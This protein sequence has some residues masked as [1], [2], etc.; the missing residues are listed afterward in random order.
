MNRWIRKIVTFTSLAGALALVPA[1]S[2]LAGEAHD[3]EQPRHGHHPHGGLVSEALKLDSL[4]GAQRD[5]LGQIEQERRAA[6]V[7][8]RQ[9]DAALLTQLAHQ[10]EQA[11]IDRTALKGQLD[12]E[13]SAAATAQGVDARTLGQLHALLTTTQRNRLV[14]QVEARLPHGKQ[15]PPALEAFRGETFDPSALVHPRTPGEHAVRHAE[16]KVPGMTPAQ[17]AAFA[18]HLR[19]RAAREAR[20]S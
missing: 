4:S 16:A 20:A 10:V 19:R 6:G 7:P 9:A 1:G 17:R 12:A 14:D 3:G 5:Q 11:A 2:A 8:L 18:D 13:Q 15:P